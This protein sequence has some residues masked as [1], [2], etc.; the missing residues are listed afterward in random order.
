MSQ[1]FDIWLLLY[2]CDMTTL[3]ND[4]VNISCKYVKTMITFVPQC[5]NRHNKTKV[6]QK[7]Q[8]K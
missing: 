1:L 4:A 5:G 6:I 8:K 7:G 2:T 3:F